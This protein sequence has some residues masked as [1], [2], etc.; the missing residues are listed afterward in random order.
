M[1]FW[2]EIIYLTCPIGRWVWNS[3]YKFH[4]LNDFIYK[5]IIWIYAHIWEQSLA[6]IFSI[7][8][9]TKLIELFP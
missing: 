9:E 3:P 5:D 4:L 2:K 1:T 7:D 8:L 6:E